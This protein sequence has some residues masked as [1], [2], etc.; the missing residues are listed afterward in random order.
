MLPD[1]VALLVELNVSTLLRGVPNTYIGITGSTVNAPG[2]I[3]HLS[4]RKSS[5]IARF[6]SELYDFAWTIPF[7][8]FG[9]D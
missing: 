3:F 5:L 1:V 9:L 8:F 2:E 4:I 6:L 7:C